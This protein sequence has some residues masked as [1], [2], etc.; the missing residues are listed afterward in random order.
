MGQHITG[1]APHQDAGFTLVEIMI[2]VAIIA[3]LAALA[4]PNLLRARL[5]ANEAVAQGTL[6]ALCTAC[7][8]FRVARSP[9]RFPLN[10]AEMTVAIPAYIDNTVDTATTGLAKKGYN[11]TYTRIN[12]RQYVCSATPEIYRATGERTFSVNETGVLRAVNN[13]GAVIDKEADY[14]ALTPCQ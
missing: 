7:E 5:A 8:N 12:D 4:I 3:M 2:V 9:M 10:M 1:C 14:Y 6:K 13:N 11:F